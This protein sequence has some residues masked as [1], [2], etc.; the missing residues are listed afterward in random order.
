M[1]SEEGLKDNF[2]NRKYSRGKTKV[3]SKFNWEKDP[4]GRILKV[5]IC[6]LGSQS[7]STEQTSLSRK[8]PSA[9][10]LYR[11]FLEVVPWA[12]NYYKF[13]TGTDLTEKIV[14]NR[15]HKM[16]Y[17]HRGVIGSGHACVSSE[18]PINKDSMRPL[19]A[20]VDIHLRNNI[21]LTK[22]ICFGLLSDVERK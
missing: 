7:F 18:H 9:G 19:M 1:R 5:V 6:C 4:L 11:R 14:W 15:L 20:P 21:V 12:A 2:R 3:V 22:A 13:I 10:P 17:S 8:F 16:F